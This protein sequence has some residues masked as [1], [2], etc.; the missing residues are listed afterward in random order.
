MTVLVTGAAGFLGSRVVDALLGAPDLLPAGARLVA[1][2]LSPVRTGDPR[3]VSAVGSIADP[4]FV[5]GLVTPGLRAVFHLA[6]ALSG[7]SEAEFDLG[8]RV[9]VDGLR[10]LLDACR[11]LQAPPRL[12]FTSTIAVYGGALPDV[13]PEDMAVQ[14]VSSYGVEKA[15]AELLVAEYTRRGYVEGVACRVPTV[16]VRPG[17]PN[18][19]LSSFV[20]GIIREPLSGSPSACPVPLETRLWISSPD[21]V[22]ANLLHAARLPMSRYGGRPIVNLPGLTVTPA[23][24]L[25]A[26]ARAAGEGARALVR[27]E[28]DERVQRVVCSW[29]GA[30]DVTRSLA[31][32][33]VR[34]ESIDAI[35]GR[36]AGTRS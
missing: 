10:A 22:V 36:F 6:A 7:Q 1:A 16:A 14:P 30:L 4:A 33:F 31:C 12:V 17:A 32:G 26:L 15:I 25:E 20:S 9:N 13:V 24:M 29:P 5:R 35:V 3:V 28:P 11:A 2:D 8:L 18:S 19:A 27:L 23:E 21:A 34:D